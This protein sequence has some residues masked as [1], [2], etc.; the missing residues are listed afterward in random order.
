MAANDH[1]VALTE[2]HFMNP[3]VDGARCATTRATQR[4][5][6]S[7][8]GVMRAWAGPRSRRRRRHAAAARARSDQ[9]HGQGGRRR[10]LR[11]AR[12]DDGRRGL[13]DVHVHQRLHHE[14]RS[15]RTRSACTSSATA[16]RSCGAAS[17]TRSGSSSTWSRTGNAKLCKVY[18][19]EDDGPLNDQRMWPFYEK[20]CELD[21]ALTIH[22]GM[23]YVLPAAEQV[24]ASVARSTTC[25]ST[26]RTCKIIAYHMAWPHHEELIGLAGKHRNLY[27]SLSGI[28]GWLAHAPYR[29]YHMIGEAL[30][31]V[32]RRQ[33]RDGPRPRLRR[34]AARS[35]TTSAISRCPKS[36]SEKWGY[37]E[38][39]D[40]T[41]AKILGLNLARLAKIDPRSA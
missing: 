24:H 10:L 41:R 27:L 36:C 28:I 35:S 3:A 34:H 39:T 20:A 22:T 9:V 38:I 1:F 33:D 14:A 29:G 19:P 15:S 7:V 17:R 6:E 30:Q 2:C 31:W 16:G 11:A 5:W 12:V 32:S 13:L 23:S 4:W 26:S 37:P 18:E 8:D 21:I 40:E 25:C